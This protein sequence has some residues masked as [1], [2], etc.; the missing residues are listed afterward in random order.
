MKRVALLATVVLCGVAT[1]SPAS[2]ASSASNG[3]WY[4]DAFHIQAA[5]DA[6]FTGKGMTIAIIDTSVNVDIPTLRDADIEPQPSLC[7]LED[8]TPVP[9]TTTSIDGLH[10]TNVASYIVGSGEG[11]DGKPG[12]KG[13]APD[14]RLLTYAT[15]GSNLDTK[16]VCEVDGAIDPIAQYIDNAVDAGADVISMSFGY[17]FSAEAALAIAHANH[18]GVIVVSGIANGLSESILD[19]AATFFEEGNGIV[20][21]QGMG[22]DGDSVKTIGGTKNDNPA[23]D[24]TGPGIDMLIQGGFSADSTWRDSTVTT[25]TS[26]AT[27]IVAGFLAL[28]EQKYPRATS[29]QILQS[30]IRNTGVGAHELGHDDHLGYGIASLT[31]MLAADPTQY[32]DVNPL[33][34]DG[35]EPS[36]EVIANPPTLEEYYAMVYGVTVAPT[37][38]PEGP[39][40]SDIGLPSIGLLVIVG[41]VVLL[42]IGLL[43]ALIA[44]AVRRSSAAGK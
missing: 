29:N 17:A 3:Q 43:I 27:P 12:V 19:Q 16:N 35:Q 8:G 41:L 22:L 6:G 26:I 20:T 21:V 40:P 25:G 37:A 5:H 18:A 13:V 28:V 11:Y 23:I 9:P 32:D 34:I 39:A 7:F 30:L 1:L 10:G 31:S 4:F 44:F 24:V 2:A 42:V 36:A 14:A 15:G 33:V 38:E